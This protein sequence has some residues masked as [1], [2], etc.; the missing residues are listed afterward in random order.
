MHSVHIEISRLRN[1]LTQLNQSLLVLYPIHKYIDMLKKYPRYSGHK[2][3]SDKVQ[4]LISRIENEFGIKTLEKYHQLLILELINQELYVPNIR[5]TSSIESH[6]NRKLLAIIQDIKRPIVKSGKYLYTQER[7]IYNLDICKGTILP[8]GPFRFNLY[9]APFFTFVRFALGNYNIRRL[10]S[11]GIGYVLSAISHSPL[12]EIHLDVF[13]KDILK[14]FSQEGWILLFQDLAELMKANPF[15]K[16]VN[17]NSWFY[18][19]QLEIVS[20]ELVYLRKYILT[21][22]GKFY[23]IGSTPNGIINATRASYHRLNLY[24]QG[25]Y[26]PVNYAFIIKRDDLINYLP[27]LIQMKG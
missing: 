24:R 19:P 8:L 18:D 27:R 13:D 16:S 23:F 12:L 22:N 4:E 7:F 2:Y 15:I 10:L 14:Y 5:L 26:I 11:D 17:G 25:K 3:I 1:E 9:K 21:L 20:P 6:L